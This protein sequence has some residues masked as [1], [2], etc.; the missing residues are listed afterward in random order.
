[1]DEED[2]LTTP[3]DSDAQWVDLESRKTS[4]KWVDKKI[5]WRDEEVITVLQLIQKHNLLNRNPTDLELGEILT[6][7]LN[8]LGFQRTPH[9]I[10]LK[11]KSLRRGYVKCKKS[12]CPEESLKECPFYDQ[13]DA[14]YSNKNLLIEDTRDKVLQISEE[15]NDNTEDIWTPVELET[16]L[17]LIREMKLSNEITLHLFSPRALRKISSALAGN[18]YSRSPT[19]VKTALQSLKTT[20]LNFKKNDQRGKSA[21]EC[22]YY[23]YLKKMWEEEYVKLPKIPQQ[24]KLLK[25][26]EIWSEEETVMLLTTIKDLDIVEEAFQNTD[27]A[28]G[29]ILLLLNDSGYTR[30]KKQIQSK[31][32]NLMQNYIEGKRCVEEAEAVRKFP[33]YFIYEKIFGSFFENFDF[34]SFGQRD[35]EDELQRRHSR[36]SCWSYKETK[37]LL[38][39]VVELNL[40]RA[41]RERMTEGVLRKL[42]APMQKRGYNRT[43][44]Q[45]KIKMKNLRM[46]YIRCIEDG[47]TV[48]AMTDCPFFNELNAIY[49]E[50]EAYCATPELKIIVQPRED[51][52]ADLKR[53]EPEHNYVQSD[54]KRVTKFRKQVIRTRSFLLKNINKEDRNTWEPI[55]TIREVNGIKLDNKVEND[56]LEELELEEE[57]E[58]DK[59]LKVNDEKENAKHFSEEFSNYNKSLE[60]TKENVIPK[61]LPPEMA[62]SE[63]DPIANFEEKSQV[64]S[65]EKLPRIIIETGTSEIIPVENLENSSAEEKFKEVSEPPLR[66]RKISETLSEDQEENEENE[67][68]EE[69]ENKNSMSILIF[70]VLEHEKKMQKQHQEWLER[71]FE[72]QREHEKEQRNILLNELKEIREAITS[73][74]NQ[75]IEKKKNNVA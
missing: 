25:S 27:L 66:K 17:L 58:I 23:C 4:Q 28:A 7:P 33:F 20:F 12:G 8:N 70:K 52:S 69:E 57:R 10:H 13:L 22:P 67:E 43:I 3:I 71:Q 15:E 48:R 73:V 64:E 50:S 59:V 68:N 44:S 47:C 9:Q 53:V 54:V 18:G 56:R 40:S 45:F 14:I 38:G 62:I 5:K 35:S 41:F 16:M 74:V 65:F 36:G 60:N 26:D 1:M 55:E 34:K 21:I 42:I 61:F 51:G 24:M 6:E 49:E 2:D 30:T 72:K 46:H 75:E 19:E 29:K 63:I 32:E 37:T 11:I 31:M 39:L